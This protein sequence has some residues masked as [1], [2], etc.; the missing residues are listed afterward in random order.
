MALRRPTQTLV[1]IG[2][3]QAG[4]PYRGKIKAYV[5]IRDEPSPA[6]KGYE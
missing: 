6:P 2:A 1:I 4:N 5:T 3:L